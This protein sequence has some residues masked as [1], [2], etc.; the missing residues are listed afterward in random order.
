MAICG[1][2]VALMAV[3]GGC[4]SDGG[5]VAS[6]GNEDGPAENVAL[7]K[8]T[9]DLVAKQ[10][11]SAEDMLACLKGKGI[12]ADLVP[13]G[14]TGYGSAEFKQIWINAEPRAVCFSLPGEG[15]MCDPAALE[16]PD[17]PTDEDRAYL[18]VDG[19]D[20]SEEL[21]ACIEETGYFTPE[22]KIDPREEEAEKQLQADASNLWAACA[23]ENG[24]PGM[25]DAKIEIDSFATMPAALVDGSVTVD[26]F[27][28]VLDQCP[29][30]DPK[31]DLGAPQDVD[32]TGPRLIDPSI[33][34]DLPEDDPKLAQLRQ[35]LDDHIAAAYEKANS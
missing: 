8:E 13:S 1:A 23:R 27:K 16:G 31:R 2:A 6:I 11:A 20:R 25:P 28:A 29:P 15:G 12:D 26:Q 9:A 7:D 35:A 17:M 19:L 34:F 30:F 33:S 14:T 32:G 3:A 4:K 5:D 22:P 21:V 10:A 24:L 18:Y